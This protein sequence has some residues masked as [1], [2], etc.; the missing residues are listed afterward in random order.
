MASIEDVVNHLCPGSIDCEPKQEAD[1]RNKSMLLMISFHLA[2]EH[3]FNQYS[4]TSFS[5]F[6]MWSIDSLDV[7]SI[8]M[9]LAIA[10]T[11]NQRLRLVLGSFLFCI[12]NVSINSFKVASTEHVLSH[13]SWG[14]IDGEPKPE[15]NVLIKYMLLV[16]SFHVSFL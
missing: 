16:M 6:Q 4:L 9:S 15:V 14:S 10:S 13:F 2:V 8:D 12:L 5:C 3:V 7:A 11:S 1:Y